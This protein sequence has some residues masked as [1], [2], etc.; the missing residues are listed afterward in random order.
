MNTNRSAP[1]ALG[2]QNSSRP[3]F[4]ADHLAVLL[5]SAVV[6]LTLAWMGISLHPWHAPLANVITG[7]SM[8][9]IALIGVALGG[10][11]LFRLLHTSA[12]SA[13]GGVSS[14]PEYGKLDLIAMAAA[15]LVMLL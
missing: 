9:W 7:C 2:N 6:V 5:Y 10:V 12:E 8:F 14:P 3:L 4:W 13:D 15:L 11:A 1:E